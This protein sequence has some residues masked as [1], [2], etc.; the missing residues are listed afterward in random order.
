MSR[1]PTP[2]ARLPWGQRA[3]LL[4]P[5]PDLL[6]PSVLDGGQATKALTFSA[7]PGWPQAS[8]S[9]GA[10]RKVRYLAAEAALVV[11]VLARYAGPA[12]ALALGD[13]RGA[14]PSGARLPAVGI[15]V[16]DSGTASL[17]A[18]ESEPVAPLPLPPST[19]AEPEPVP[20][21]S[22][23]ESVYYEN[24]DAAR[25]A[26]AAPLLLGQPGYRAELDRNRDGVACEW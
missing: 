7:Q 9:A 19:T 20:E 1:P 2:A 4:P 26:G 25:A 18:V 11:H 5:A 16:H 3:S 23:A 17:A 24:C 13:C 12:Y 21:V 22:T 10:Q 8:Q 6:D 14:R 15:A